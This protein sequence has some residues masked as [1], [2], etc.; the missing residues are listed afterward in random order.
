MW[1]KS[2]IDN[3]QDK[4]ALEGIAGF[5]VG[6][7][8]WLRPDSGI[9]MAFFVL[10]NLEYF[11]IR[12][13]FTFGIGFILSVIVN[14]LLDLIYFGKFFVTF[15]NFLRFNSENQS[16]FGVSPFGWYF[17]NLILNRQTYF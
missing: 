14:G 11:R 2:G 3:R 13:I 8:I 5:L 16:F 12:K 6:V 7:S 17:Q 10:L 4:W 9:V 1:I 15:P